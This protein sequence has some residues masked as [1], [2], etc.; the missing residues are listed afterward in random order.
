MKERKAPRP[1]ETPDPESETWKAIPW[2][3]QEQHVSAVP[4]PKGGGHDLNQTSTAN[5][6]EERITIRYCRMAAGQQTTLAR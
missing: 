5:A 6:R 2:R 1:G 3:K 4:S